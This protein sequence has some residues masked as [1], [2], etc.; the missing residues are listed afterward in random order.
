M[1]RHVFGVISPK[2]TRPCTLQQLDGPPNIESGFCQQLV[3][4]S[5]K[6]VSRWPGQLGAEPKS[7]A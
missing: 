3:Q 1:R 4:I 5:S 7:P 2:G 6:G